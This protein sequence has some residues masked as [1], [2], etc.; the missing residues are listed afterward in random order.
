M[1]LSGHVLCLATAR[2]DRRLAAGAAPLLHQLDSFASEV[3][4]L[5]SSPSPLEAGQLAEVARR[6][7]GYEVSILEMT[8][9][10]HVPDRPESSDALA[11]MATQ[12]GQD[13]DRSHAAAKSF[14]LGGSAA[15]LVAFAVLATGLTSSYFGNPRVG[16]VVF[17]YQCIAGA[18]VCAVAGI[19]MH[20]LGERHRQ[21][22]EEFVRMQRQLATVNPY[23]DP[24]PKAQQ[25][26]MRA[27]LASRLFPRLTQ[28][29][30]LM[31]MPPWPTA[32]EII[33]SETL[34]LEASGAAQSRPRW[35]PFPRR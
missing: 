11:H 1:S 18:G 28:D 23:L 7:A 17:F 35:F 12:Y 2:G 27:T 4:A 32:E 3:E 29:D 20:V 9:T 25:T 16:G 10:N 31:M 21:S 34:N 26:L 5:A 22:A 15:W 13:A 30:D 14:R 6:G 24:L 19:W 33:R 8:S